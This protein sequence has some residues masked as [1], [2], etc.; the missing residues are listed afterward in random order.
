MAAAWAV[1]NIAGGS[2]AHTQHMVDSGAVAALM[3]TANRC[4]ATP[5]TPAIAELRAR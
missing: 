5:W 4:A 2:S 1:T 3:A